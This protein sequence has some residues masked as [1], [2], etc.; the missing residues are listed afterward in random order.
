VAGLTYSASPAGG[1]KLGVKPPYGMDSPRAISGGMATGGV[2]QAFTFAL[3]LD[4][5]GPLWYRGRIIPAGRRPLT[6]GTFTAWYRGRA[7]AEVAGPEH[8]ATGVATGGMRLGG[9]ATVVYDHAAH[10]GSGR[11][12]PP[13]GAIF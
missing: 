1:L 11:A 12:H 3:I 10:A 4:F 7:F 8:R 9:T 5:D 2:A 13:W 6:N